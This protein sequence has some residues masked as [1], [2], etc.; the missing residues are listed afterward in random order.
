MGDGVCKRVGACLGNTP[1]PL[2]LKLTYTQIPCHGCNGHT[3]CVIKAGATEWVK[4]YG[5]AYIWLN[6]AVFW[7]KML[8][9]WLNLFLMLLRTIA[10]EITETTCP[11]LLGL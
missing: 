9:H 3:L 11:V 5:N 4:L 2:P 10:S 8:C 6:I 1:F 7:D